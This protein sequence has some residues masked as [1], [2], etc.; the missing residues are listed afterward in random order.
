M[1]AKP[2]RAAAKRKAQPPARRLPLVLILVGVL[3]LL[4]IAAVVA[5]RGGDGDETSTA[6]GLE[7]TRPVTVT[8]TPLPPH[9]EGDDTA[10]GAAAP[11]VRGASFDGA[12]V[13]ITNDGRPKVLAFLAHWCPHC[14]R[15]VPVLVD[16]LRAN[17]NPEGVDL[18]GIA[19]STTP[20]RPN[21]PPSAWLEREGWRVPTLVDDADGTTARAFG[22]SGFP[23]FVAVD[24]DGHVVARTSGELSPSQFEALLEQAR[25]GDAAAS[26]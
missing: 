13:E 25:T 2:T 23:F 9:G 18:Y 15:E 12:P 14:Q 19:T 24:R 3:V 22:L 11:E 6:A 17:G 4:G 8:G 20:E 10:V 1:P 5:S 26:P 21:Y 16:W 7:Q